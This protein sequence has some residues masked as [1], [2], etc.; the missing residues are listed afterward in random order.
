VDDLIVAVAVT[1]CHLTDNN[2]LRAGVWRGVF[3]CQESRRC[4]C[5]ITSA[6]HGWWPVTDP[7]PSG[8]RCRRHS[9][10]PRHYSENCIQCQTV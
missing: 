9:R 3:D 7:G 6:L 4:R 10:V 8:K 2:L 1:A 5:R